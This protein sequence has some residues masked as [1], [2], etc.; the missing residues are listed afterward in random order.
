MKL[1]LKGIGKEFDQGNGKQVS[2]LKDVS[3]RIDDESIVSILGPS[4]CGKTTLLRIMA[5]LERPTSG[6][7][8]LDGEPIVRP[9][10]RMGMIFQEHALLPWLSVIENVSLG[11]EMRG[12]PA[13]QRHETAMKYLEMVGLQDCV[14]SRSYEL[15]GG[16]RQRAAVARALSLEPSILLMD[17]PFSALDPQTRAQIQADILRIQEKTAKAVILVTHS[18]E[19]ALILSDE[20]IILSSRPGRVKELTKVGL[21]RPRDRMNPSFLEMKE[22]VLANLNGGDQ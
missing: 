9:S 17:E 19:E 13:G 12:I 16:M 10:P 20:L 21:G 3:F 4:G 8:L 22:T 5:G 14:S 6:K 15:S 7:V 1:E 18:V 11:L 2:V